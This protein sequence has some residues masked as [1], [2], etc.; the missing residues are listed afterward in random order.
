VLVIVVRMRIILASQIVPTTNPSSKFG[1]KED[2]VNAR[3]AVSTVQGFRRM[4]AQLAIYT[5][6][7]MPRQHQI[8]ISVDDLVSDGMFHA[9]Q[10]MTG[11]WFD[12][13]KSSISTAIHHT[14]RN[15]LFNEYI[16]KY[17]NERRFASLESAGIIDYDA[18]HKKTKKGNTPA[19][20]IS[21]DIPPTEQEFSP[22][23][24]STSEDTIYNN[25]L[26]DCFVVPVLGKIYSEASSKLRD[27]MIM[28]FLQQPDKMHL[29]GLKFRVAAKEFRMLSKE[30]DLTYFDCEHLIHSPKCMNRLSHEL[31]SVPYDLD[32]PTPIYNKE[33]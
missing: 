32:H 3:K 12:N 5:W 23:Q 1:C 28:W 10:V 21:L 24:L 17:G 14:V 30:F 27:Q 8:W 16:A 19:S 20:L 9:Y 26:T 7:I 31:L 15:H 13:D 33:L 2:R 18:K 11:E 25:V 22:L 4:I 29:K 6:K